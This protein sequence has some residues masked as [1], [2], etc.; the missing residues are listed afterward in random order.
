MP[1]VNYDQL[2]DD[3][4]RMSSKLKNEE[5][6]MQRAKGRLDQLLADIKKEY[7]VETVEELTELKEQETAKIKRIS[8]RIQNRMKE[9]KDK[10]GN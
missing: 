4:K 5:E 3:M 10:L 6:D 9:I 2:E 1:E 8:K 7:D